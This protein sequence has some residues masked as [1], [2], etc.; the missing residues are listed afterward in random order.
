MRDGGVFPC[1]PSRFIEEI[2]AGLVREMRPSG[3]G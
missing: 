1:K 2:D 3:Y